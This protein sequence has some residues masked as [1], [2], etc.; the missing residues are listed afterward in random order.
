MKEYEF[1]P[2]NIEHCMERADALKALEEKQLT[3]VM[4]TETGEWSSR[5]EDALFDSF[6]RSLRYR[7]K[8]TPVARPWRPEEVPIGCPIRENGKGTG[9][10]IIQSLCTECPTPYVVMLRGNLSGE[11]YVDTVSME[12][13]SRFWENYSEERGWKPCTTTEP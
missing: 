11:A 12:M 5:N 13:L 9:W 7:R 8:P 10:S 1:N 3:Q 6:E 4:R 2:N